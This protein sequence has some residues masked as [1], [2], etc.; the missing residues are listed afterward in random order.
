MIR[1]KYV[2]GEIEFFQGNNYRYLWEENMFEVVTGNHKV[3]LPVSNVKSIGCGMMV[4]GEF[5]YD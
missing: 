3:L 5:K 2:N 4:N 1:V